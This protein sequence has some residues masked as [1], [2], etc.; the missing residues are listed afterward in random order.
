MG[1]GAGEQGHWPVQ[2]E[3]NV[4]L[5]VILDTEVPGAHLVM[6]VV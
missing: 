5:W 1:G 6:Q 3:A 2:N 4:H